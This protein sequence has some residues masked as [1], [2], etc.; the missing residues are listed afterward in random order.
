MAAVIGNEHLFAREHYPGIS[1]GDERE[2]GSDHFM[3]ERIAFPAKSASQ[4]GLD[5]PNPMVRYRKHLSQRQVQVMWDL[6]R[7]I[8][9]QHPLRGDLHL[10]RVRF[11]KSVVYR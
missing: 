4:M 11:G 5:N 9:G 2:L 10:G 1:S 6:G 7:R 3:R 8:D